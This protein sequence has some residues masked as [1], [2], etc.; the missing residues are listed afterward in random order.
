MPQ[1]DSGQR[2]IRPLRWRVQS[3][4]NLHIA[5]AVSIVCGLSAHRVGNWLRPQEPPVELRRCDITDYRPL[6]F[7]GVAARGL[8]RTRSPAG[9]GNGFDVLLDEQ[10]ATVL[11]NDRFK[12]AHDPGIAALDHRHADLLQ[13]ERDD[14]IHQCG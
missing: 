14:A 10:L 8:D 1:H 3:E 5:T 11:A 2:L 7:E 13:R 6:C 12:C 9:G 4:M